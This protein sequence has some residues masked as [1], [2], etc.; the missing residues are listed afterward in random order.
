VAETINRDA[1]GGRGRLVGAA[2]TFWLLRGRF[3]G[4]V[5]VAYRGKY[6]D[7]DGQS[8]PWEDIESWGML[9]PDDPTYFAQGWTEKMAEGVTSF[10]RVHDESA[11]RKAWGRSEHV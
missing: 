8:K 9:A 1:F 6:Y 7:A 10:R 4:H 5:A 11:L 3:I 2:N